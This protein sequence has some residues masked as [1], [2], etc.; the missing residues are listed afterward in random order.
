MKIAMSKIKM[1]NDPQYKQYE[2]DWMKD[3]KTK[4]NH[5]IQVEEFMLK[6]GQEVPQLP[7]EPLD[8]D[9]ILRAKLILEEALETA[10]ALGVSIYTSI[11]DGDELT[12]DGLSWS[13]TKDF[14]ITKVIDGC[15][16][17]AV[18]TTGTLSACGIED[19]PVQ[20]AVNEA[21]LRKFGPGGHRRDDG[22]W[23]KPPDFVGPEKDI[24][25]YLR[26]KD[27]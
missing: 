1:P 16:D 25:D 22:K 26:S 20:N 7:T 14:N 12:M 6:A 5:Q 24:E 21:N 4:S 10:E 27:D 15:A 11:M 23:I 19:I 17:I 13:V 3:S 2:M 18:V 8:K 9:K